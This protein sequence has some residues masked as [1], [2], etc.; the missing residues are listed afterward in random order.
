MKYIY[1]LMIAFFMLGNS[2]NAQFFIENDLIRSELRKAYPACFNTQEVLDTS[3]AAILSAKKIL[4]DYNTNAYRYFYCGLEDSVFADGL[5][6]FKSADTLILNYPCRL[7]IIRQHLP[8]QLKVAHIFSDVYREQVGDMESTVISV[9]SLPESLEELAIRGSFYDNNEYGYQN[10]DHFV[11]VRALPGS[12]KKLNVGFKSALQNKTLPSSI[13]SFTEYSKQ[14]KRE[15]TLNA[16]LEEFVLTNIGRSG[17]TYVQGSGYVLPSGLK[18]FG[19]SASAFD[20]DAQGVY[21][22]QTIFN[23]FQIPSGLQSLAIRSSNTIN[24]TL[25]LPGNLSKLE[26]IKTLVNFNSLPASLDTLNLEDGLPFEGTGLSIPNNLRYLRIWRMGLQAFPTLPSSLLHL[27]LGANPAITQV[28]S[29]WPAGLKVLLLNSA[30]LIAL[31]TLPA[32]LEQLDVRFNRQLGC[33][34]PLPLSLQLLNINSTAITCI[35]NETNIIKATA[36]LPL[37]ALPCGQTANYAR[38]KV[39]LD[40]NQNGTFQAGVDQ[41]L[42]NMLLRLQP[43]GNQTVTDAE[44]NYEIL[45]VPDT[46]NTL[47]IQVNQPHIA[48]LTPGSYVF[49]NISGDEINKDFAITFKNV[50]DLEVYLAATAARPGFEHICHATVLNSGNIQP[51]GIRLVIKK[52]GDW[53]NSFVSPAASITSNDSIVWDNIQIPLGQT[54]MFT[55]RARLPETADIL[56]NPYAV[57]ASVTPVIDD[58]TPENNVAVIAAV[59]TGSYDP[60]DKLVNLSMIPPD[61]PAEQELIYTI[62]FQNTGTDTAFT[63]VIKDTV[64]SNLRPESIRV[65]GA[66]HDYKFNMQENVAVFT[67]ENILLPDSNVNEPGS[68]GFVT[69]ALKTKAGLI[70][71][72]QFENRAAIFFDFNEPIITNTATTEVKLL[73]HVAGQSIA[74]VSAFPNPTKHSIKVTWQ[75]SGQAILSVYDLSGK[76]LRSIQVSESFVE[77]DMSEYPSGM[78]FIQLQVNG[79]LGMM[80]VQVQK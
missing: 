77:L 4:L 18:H 55:F 67:F 43:S 71:G 79:R 76:Y 66:S 57:T 1:A 50:K 73:S 2:A 9:I 8:P 41:P 22:S 54:R 27:D 48:S 52:P 19:I 64:L 74:G 60:N 51:E 28:P 61:Y 47:N 38:G 72:Q 75:E 17:G 25:P 32:Q 80:K 10:Y 5:Q 62:R 33:L 36:Q 46:T 21:P 44:G 13:R 3:C 53:Q 24:Y 35:P 20:N 23:D 7:D 45:L 65:I 40:V 16:G 11:L 6:F 63:V 39:Y 70:E 78:Y 58:V 14:A 56:G 49:N 37:C 29:Q 12:V 59:I 42:R 26:V 34:P 30:N 68:H 31:P 15:Y 69:L